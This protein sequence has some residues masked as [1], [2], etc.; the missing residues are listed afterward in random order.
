MDLLANFTEALKKAQT[1]DPS[2]CFIIYKSNNQ[3]IVAYA[4]KLDN[5]SFNLQKLD[6]FAGIEGKQPQEQVVYTP[7]C[8]EV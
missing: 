2:I 3:N 4:S 8:Y 7:N 5:N 1:E 6:D